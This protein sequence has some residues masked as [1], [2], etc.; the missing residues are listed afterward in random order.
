MKE[1]ELVELLGLGLGILLGLVPAFI[2]KR[3]NRN[4]FLW[5]IYGSL[6]FFI[7]LVH[8]LSLSGRKGE[9]ISTTCLMCQKPTAGEDRSLRVQSR[10]LFPLCVACHKRC[11]DMPN[12]IVD[13]H[14]HLFS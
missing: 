2:A 7:A 3:K 14:P 5:W 6:C 11:V 12:Q 9:R 13:E 4:F 1:R 8:S 10:L